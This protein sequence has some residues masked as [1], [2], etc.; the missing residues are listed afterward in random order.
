VDDIGTL[1]ALASRPVPTPSQR[2]VMRLAQWREK[3]GVTQQELSLAT[4]ISTSTIRRL[5]NPTGVERANP[6]IRYLQN[7]ALALGCKVSDLIE[8][9]W[10][11]WMVFDQRRPAPPDAK[12]FWRSR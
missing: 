9:E 12:E 2:R 7:C 1:G 10:Q 3:R 4:G 6:P 5:E 8:P 11:E